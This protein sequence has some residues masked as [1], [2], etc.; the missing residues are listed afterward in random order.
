MDKVTAAAVPSR[1][2]RFY[3][4]SWACGGGRGKTCRVIWCAGGNFN[5]SLTTFA[6]LGPIEQRMEEF[7]GEERSP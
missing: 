6:Y 1:K 5:R 7:H 2:A 3:W 4:L